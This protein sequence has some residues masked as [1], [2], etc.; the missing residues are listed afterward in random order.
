VECIDLPKD[1]VGVFVD[2][3]EVPDLA[4]FDPSDRKFVALGLRAKAP[5]A[6]ATDSD[7]VLAKSALSKQG[8]TLRFLCGENP[9]RWFEK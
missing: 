8:L 4:M 5:V 1:A 3:P 9:G 7:R 6:V 2:F